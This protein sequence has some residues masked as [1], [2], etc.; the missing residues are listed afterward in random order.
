MALTTRAAVKAQ[1]NIA[2]TDTTYDQQIDKLIDGITSLVK[3]VLNRDLE[4]RTYT[5]YYS[6]D[7]SSILLLRQF[8]VVS[9][10]S[11]YFDSGSYFGQAD[12]AFPESSK[13]TEAVDY[14]VIWGHSGYGA[15]G[16]IRRINDVWSTRTSRTSGRLPDLPPNPIGNI[17]VTYSAGFAQIP[18]AIQMAV[19]SEVYRAC[20]QPLGP[21]SSNSYEGASESFLSPD[22]AS[23]VFSAIGNVF[24]RYRRIAV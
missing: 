10:A 19:N 22:Q 16:E 14:A 5:E 9:V 7:A 20:Q 1:A 15:T 2:A 21:V 6:G 12:N 8:P 4:L 24:G 13:L 23:Q 3:R 17:K 11:I 18:Q